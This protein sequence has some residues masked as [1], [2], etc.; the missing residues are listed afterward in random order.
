[1][2]KKFCDI[3]GKEVKG[4]LNVIEH[5]DLISYDKAFRKFEK[6]KH[7]KHERRGF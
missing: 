4:Q 5:I 2:I 1:M 7:G 3:C 6:R